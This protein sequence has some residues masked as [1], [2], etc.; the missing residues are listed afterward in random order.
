MIAPIAPIAPISPIASID[1][2]GRIVN[3]FVVLGRKM[4]FLNA[5]HIAQP[6]FLILSRSGLISVDVFAFAFRV[7]V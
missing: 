2:G 7:S 6:V 4:N 1:R 3:Y 5:T